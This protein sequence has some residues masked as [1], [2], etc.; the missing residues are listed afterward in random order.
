MRTFPGRFTDGLRQDVRYA[1]RGLRRS[2]AFTFIVLAS[3]AV[4]IGANTAMFSF[5]NAV[6]IKQLP[7]AEPDRLVTFTRTSGAASSP[8]VWPLTTIEELSTESSALNGVFGWFTT[9]I[10]WSSES[11]AQWVSGDLVTGQYFHTLQVR[12][13]LGRLL[14]EDDV[15][16]ADPVCVLSYAFW[17]RA[18]GG[19]PNIAD[20]TVSLNGH[21]YRVIGVELQRRF[22]VAIPATRIGDFI[23]TFAGPSGDARMRNM[24]WLAPIARLA[25]KISRVDAERQVAHTRWAFGWCSAHGRGTWSRCSDG[26]A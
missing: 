9:P 14:D 13:A 19:D 21:P 4:A 7:V 23:P 10:S 1:L 15:R 25:P 16:A 18:F 3:L 8:V 20:R 24:S 5:V 12:P 17:H 2:P 6:L 22:D 26:R 11:D